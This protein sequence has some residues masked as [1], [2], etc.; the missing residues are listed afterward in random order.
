MAFLIKNKDCQNHEDKEQGKQGGEDSGDRKQGGVLI[1]NE[2]ADFVPVS[3]EWEGIP[4]SM[5]EFLERENRGRG[6]LKVRVIDGR[7]IQAVDM[8]NNYAG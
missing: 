7:I 1:F 8:G 2:N 5:S 6:V 4:K 3:L